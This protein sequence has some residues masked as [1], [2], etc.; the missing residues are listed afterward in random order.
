MH[1]GDQ[2]VQDRSLSEERLVPLR[3][4]E[5]R[6]HARPE[7]NLALPPVQE[8][9]AVANLPLAHDQRVRQEQARLEDVDQLRHDV[10]WRTAEEV[11]L[12]DHAQFHEREHALAHVLMQIVEYF[13][14]GLLVQIVH[15]TCP[16][17]LH[18]SLR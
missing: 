11:G 1:A 16:P 7:L 14:L 15:P 10:V 18:P 5:D 6:R 17:R 9:H 3:A 13:F 8:E 2:L 12:L 4:D